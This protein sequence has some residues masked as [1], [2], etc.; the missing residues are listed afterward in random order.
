M[1]KALDILIIVIYGTIGFCAIR[2]I[3]ARKRRKYITVRKKVSV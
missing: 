2:K 3:I 1:K